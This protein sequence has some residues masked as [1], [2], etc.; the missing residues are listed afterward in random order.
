MEILVSIG[1]GILYFMGLDFLIYYITGK[2]VIWWAKFK[3][4]IKEDKVL[5]QYQFEK[6]VK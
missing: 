3:R 4:Q 5:E 1:L 2:E 6:K